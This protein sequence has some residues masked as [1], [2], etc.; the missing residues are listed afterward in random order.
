MM[1]GRIASPV[2]V[3]NPL[4]SHRPIQQMQLHLP[5]MAAERAALRCRCAYMEGR[6]GH[7]HP[8]VMRVAPSF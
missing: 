3:G 2:H 6:P 5:M 1:T 8:Q 7:H 4:S